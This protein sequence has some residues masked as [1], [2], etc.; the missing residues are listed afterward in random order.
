MVTPHYQQVHASQRDH[1][2]HRGARN[3]G[4]GA[5]WLVAGLLITVITLANSDHGGVYVIA[6]GPIVGGAVQLIIG[7]RQ[8]HRAHT[9]ATSPSTTAHTAMPRSSVPPPRPTPTTRP[10]ARTSDTTWI[11]QLS[12]TAGLRRDEAIALTRRAERDGIAPAEG[13]AGTNAG[14][15]IVFRATDTDAARRFLESLTV[16]ERGL[17]YMVETADG[18]WGADIDGLY[19]QNL[20]AWQRDTGA[21]THSGQVVR[22]HD[23]VTGLIN[24]ARGGLDNFTVSVVCGRCAGQWSDGVRYRDV[25]ATCCPHCHALNRVDTTH[26]RVTIVASPDDD[27]V[28]AS[29]PVRP[30][31]LTARQLSSPAVV[32]GRLADLIDGSAEAVADR[33]DS[34]RHLALDVSHL[35][36]L[37]AAP[38]STPTWL[39]SH[40][41]VRAIGHQLERDGGFRA[42]QRAHDKL[43][44][45]HH[46]ALVI[47]DAL[48]DRIGEWRS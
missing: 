9:A 36:T 41:E 27:V 47:V 15:S 17:R 22:V 29:L 46:S 18:T 38:D 4:F 12:R 19:L 20:R 2:R 40:V 30:A 45:D 32:A 39:A 3:I 37:I 48:W 5:L 16:N 33:P 11:D 10:G 44:P 21:A 13:E 14:R 31:P 1:W 34:E 23:T 24:A 42:M 6:F 8:R 25:T 26:I 7:L 43:L 28:S 35:D